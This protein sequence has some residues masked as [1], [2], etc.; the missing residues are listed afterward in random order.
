MMAVYRVAGS[1]EPA[2]YTWTDST[3]TTPIVAWLGAYTGVDP[4]APV[5]A[6]HAKTA[7]QT[8]ATAHP[9]NAAMSTANSLELLVMGF[10]VAASATWTAPTRTTEC[11]AVEN[12]TGTIV[13][14]DVADAFQSPAAATSAWI[15]TSSTNNDGVTLI[16][17]LKPLAANGSTL[18]SATVSVNGPGGPTLVSTGAFATSAV[19]FL[20]GDVLVLDVTVPNDGNCGVRISF[21]STGQ[22]SKLTVATIVPEGVAGLLLL[23]PALPFALRIRKRK[24]P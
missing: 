9:T 13:S 22:P 3:T 23:A 2:T 19:T 17:A 6:T 10:A 12:T 21:D 18:G 16:A 7:E 20:G 4:A 14:M 1:S 5:D 8:P 24:L 15:A 11:A